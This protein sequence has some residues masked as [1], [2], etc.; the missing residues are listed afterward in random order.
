MDSD[1][2]LELFIHDYLMKMNRPASA[3][4]FA[5]EANLQREDAP[6]APRDTPKGYLFDSFSMFLDEYF[7]EMSKGG[8]A[9]EDSLSKFR[10]VPEVIE[11]VLA[12]MD[13]VERMSTVMSNL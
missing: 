2:M 7:A 8:K 3:V 6:V 11:R 9:A 10:L 13:L 5:R 1:K 4:V 12:K